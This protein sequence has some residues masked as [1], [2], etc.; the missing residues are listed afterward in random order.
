MSDKFP[1]VPTWPGKTGYYEAPMSNAMQAASQSPAPELCPICNHANIHGPHGCTHEDE[2]DGDGHPTICG[3][4]SARRVA[5]S[6][7]PAP[8][9]NSLDSFLSAMKPV[10]LP[11]GEDSVSAIRRLRDAPQPNSTA[12]ENSCKFANKCGGG[13]STAR[14]YLDVYE[15]VIKQECGIDVYEALD[16]LEAELAQLRAEMANATEFVKAVR[17][18]CFDDS[19]WALYI[20]QG[21]PHSKFAPEEDENNA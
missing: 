13:H 16:A 21:F 17:E 19:A 12:P 10:P 8:Q 3:C 6:Q 14:H 15:R 7:A 4:K 11:E 2:W 1:K 9:P 18:T 5:A 20:D